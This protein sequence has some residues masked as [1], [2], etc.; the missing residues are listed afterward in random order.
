MRNDIP[1]NTQKWKWSL[2]KLCGMCVYFGTFLHQMTDS[3]DGDLT[4]INAND[5]Y[6]LPT[7]QYILMQ[8]Y[9]SR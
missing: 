6:L 4:K 2:F 3:C 1:I 9:N 8:S 7:F 5:G